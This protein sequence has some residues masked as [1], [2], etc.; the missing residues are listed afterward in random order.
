[1]CM[2][3]CKKIHFLSDQT[4]IRKAKLG[5]SLLNHMIRNMKS[6]CCQDAIT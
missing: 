6:E 3:A 2:Q 1:M 5:K 4:E